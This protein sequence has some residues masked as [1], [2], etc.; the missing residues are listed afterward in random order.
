MQLKAESIHKYLVPLWREIEFIIF[1]FGNHQCDDAGAAEDKESGHDHY[2]ELLQPTPPLPEAGG[3]HPVAEG[4][5]DEAHG[6]GL[7]TEH[8]TGWGQGALLH[9][10]GVEVHLATVLSHHL[11]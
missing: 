6:P 5:G 11:L 2:E 3:P 7:V 4:R 1:L 9:H 8:L 10:L